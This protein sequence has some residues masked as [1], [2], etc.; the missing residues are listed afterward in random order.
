[1]VLR[2]TGVFV[3]CGVFFFVS[4]ELNRK[5]HL[6]VSLVFIVGIQVKI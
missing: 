3:G 1:M 6:L 5:Y 2:R 4:S